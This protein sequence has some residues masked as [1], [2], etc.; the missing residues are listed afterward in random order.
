MSAGE[1]SKHDCL[2]CSAFTSQMATNS[3]SFV[4]HIVARSRDIQPV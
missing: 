2:L 3:R 4:A 1:P